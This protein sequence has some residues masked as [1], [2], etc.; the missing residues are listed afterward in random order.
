MSQQTMRGMR[1]GTTSLESE[2][3]VSFSERSKHVFQCAADHKTEVVFAAEAELPD[4]W[5]CRIC[6]QSAVRLAD[7]KG[8]VAQLEPEAAP[9][10]HWEMLLERRTRE[11]LEELLAERI[12]YIR[13]RRAMGKAEI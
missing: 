3:G 7:G 5:Q 9:R 4:T 13:S 11:E 10:S 6:S 8:M 2:V 12:E 1:L